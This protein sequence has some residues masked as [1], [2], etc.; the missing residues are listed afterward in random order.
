MNLWVKRVGQLAM[1]AV[2]LFFLQCEEETSV[3]GYKNPNSKFKV[4]YVEIPIESSVFLRDSLRTTNFTYSGEPNRFM[5]GKYF[6]ETFGDITA[7]SFTQYFID[8]KTFKNLGSTAVYDSV[9]LELHFDLYHYGATALTP[10]TISIYEL[11]EELKTDSAKVYSNDSSVPRSLNIGSK[12]F[13]VN[14]AKFDEFAGSAD[15][16]DTVITIKFPLDANFGNRIFNSAVK[17][18]DATSEADS[19]FIH[20]SEFIKEFK[21]IAI[22]GETADKIIGFSPVSPASRIVV[23]YHENDTVRRALNMTFSGV[24]GFNQIKANRTGTVLEPVKQHY[25]TVL[26]DDN[27]RYIQSGIGILTKLDFSKFYEFTDT[28]PYILINSAELS[29]ESVQASTYAP[30]ASL[31]LRV[32]KDNN[33]MKVYVAK[34]EQDAQ[35]YLSYQGLLRYDVGFQSSPA[36][37]DSDSVFYA[38]DKSN[39]LNYSSKDNSYKMLMTLFTQRLTVPSENVTKF[40]YFVLHPAAQNPSISPAAQSGLKSVNRV[41]FPKDKIKL[42]IYY[43]KPTTTQ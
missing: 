41:I 27:N 31:S 38:T 33:R 36:I 23:H 18:R 8:T 11:D 40:K 2:A 17:L 10:Q 39:V 32:L 22:E 1:L 14:T 25:Q 24:I 29:I 12:T 4:S 30:P 5:V 3:L 9:S 37:V 20:F 34:N 13:T 7:A 28:V 42:K 16:K 43:T 21:G 6:D 15:T 35:D 26:Q 19:T